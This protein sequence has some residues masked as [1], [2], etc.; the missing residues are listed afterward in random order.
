MEALEVG[1]NF[2]KKNEGRRKDEAIILKE[3]TK[4]ARTKG[5]NAC[6]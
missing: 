3:V 1:P 4:Y 6:A 5:H 2:T